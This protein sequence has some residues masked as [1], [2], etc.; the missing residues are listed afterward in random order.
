MNEIEEMLKKRK[1]EIDDICVP[2]ELENRLRS[3]LEKQ[4]QK[5]KYNSKWMVKVASILIIFILIGY[6]LD[7]LAYFGKKIIGFDP[8]MSE[9]LKELN[10]NG[11]GQVIGKSFTFNNGTIVTLDGVMVDDNQLLLFYTE[12]NPKGNIH[13]NG[14]DGI[15]TIGGFWGNHH[16]QSG[17]GESNDERTETKWIMSFDPPYFFQKNLTWQF[18]INENGKMESGEISFKLDRSKA[19]GHTLKSKL[20]KTLKLNNREIKFDSIQASSTTTIIKGTIQNILELAKDQISGERMMPEGLEIDLI[21]NGE[22]LQHQ[23]SGMGTNLRGIKFHQDFEPLLE[24]LEEL[25]IKIVG[26]VADY[27]TNK[28][29]KISKLTNNEFISIEDQYININKVYEENGET[30]VTITSQDHVVLTRVYL[31][32]DGKK[33]E[34]KNTTPYKMEKSEDGTITHTRTLR[35]IGRGEDL[36]L[37]IERIRYNKA[38]DIIIDIPIN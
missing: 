38:M 10:E 6:N 23:G 13:D 20:N 36:E 7:T 26:F 24:E 21:A 12:S 9:S 8:I 15:M 16:S 5:S 34:L 3:A 31:V 29:V 11:K 17:R 37:S 4:P 19:M 2:D 22:E 35:F 28:K 27:N 1:T 18:Q 30:F 14:I 33:V 32:M 25:Q